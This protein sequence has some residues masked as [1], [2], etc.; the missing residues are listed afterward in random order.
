VNIHERIGLQL[1]GCEP[2][3]MMAR[4]YEV[5]NGGKPDFA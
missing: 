4:C 3:T 2:K 1:G 5:V